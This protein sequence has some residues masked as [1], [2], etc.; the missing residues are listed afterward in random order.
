MD[1]L[2]VF[3]FPP[4]VEFPQEIIPEII[5]LEWEAIKQEHVWLYEQTNYR[6][7]KYP[8]DPVVTSHTWNQTRIKD[9]QHWIIA[10]IKTAKTIEFVGYVLLLPTPEFHPG[11]PL[12]DTYLCGGIGVMPNY[13]KQGIGTVLLDY[14]CSVLK[15]MN[16]HNFMISNLIKNTAADK[17]YSRMKFE[18]IEHGYIG[19]PKKEAVSTDFIPLIKYEQRTTRMD[20]KLYKQ[21]VDMY[22]WQGRRFY[23]MRSVAGDVAKS[24]MKRTDKQQEPIWV[25]PGE[26][27]WCTLGT[28]G[29]NKLL[30]MYPICITLKGIQAPAQVRKYLWFLSEFGKKRKISEILD[31]T[32]SDTRVCQIVESAGIS[33]YSVTRAKAL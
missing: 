25:F 8:A 13:R 1:N 7:P 33:K 28:S 19:T 4:E 29:D 6:T 17:L 27:G 15:Q 3:Y 2:E 12:L 21:L 31:F 9:R 11:V 16:I 22:Q 18:I 30:L 5:A 20:A 10:V 32:V 24:I 14:T 26:H 23:P